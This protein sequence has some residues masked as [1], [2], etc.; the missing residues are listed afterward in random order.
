MTQDRPR[1]IDNDA[2]E[3]TVSINGAEVRGWSYQNDSERRLKMLVAREF[4]E[5]WYEGYSSGLKRAGDM[6]EERA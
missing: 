3:I 1:L 6:L 2:G 5:G 4:V